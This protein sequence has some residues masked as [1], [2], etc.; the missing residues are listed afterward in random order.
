MSHIC[1]FLFSWKWGNHLRMLCLVLQWNQT[2]C[3]CSTDCKKS[4]IHPATF[5]KGVDFHKLIEVLQNVST[6][7]LTASL[8]PK[9]LAD[10]TILGLESS[11]FVPDVGVLF[12]GLPSILLVLLRVLPFSAPRLTGCGGFVFYSLCRRSFILYAGNVS[13]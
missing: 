6:F 13:H 4:K 12:P 5:A 3:I 10:L 1:N 11:S 8:A 2:C 7:K 9:N